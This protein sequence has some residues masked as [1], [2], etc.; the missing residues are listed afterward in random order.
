MSEGNRIVFT[1]IAVTAAGIATGFLFRGQL[2]PAQASGLQHYDEMS[3]TSV[4]KT[5]LVHGHDGFVQH[6]HSIIITTTVT[7][8]TPHGDFHG[9]GQQ[10]APWAFTNTTVIK[11]GPNE[12]WIYGREFMPGTLTVAAGTTVT[13]RN[14]N[15]EQHTVTSNTSL[16]NNILYTVGSTLDSFSYTFTQPGTYYYYC[17]PHLNGGMTGKIIVTPK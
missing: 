7:E 17:Q 13:W 4:N 12:V 3:Q 14:K 10:M 1:F 15:S 5:S 2:P 16:F 6:D 11:Q 8:T 9:F